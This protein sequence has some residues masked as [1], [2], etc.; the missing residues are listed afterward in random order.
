MTEQAAQSW[1]SSHRNSIPAVEIFHR[2]ALATLE[3][4]NKTVHDL[5]EIVALDPG[6]SISLFQQVN[7]KLQQRGKDAVESAHAAL[8]LLGDSAIADFIMQHQVLDAT[9]PDPAERQSYLQLISRTYH[10]QAQLEGFIDFQGISVVNEVLSAALL[11]NIGEFLACLFDYKQ[12]QQYQIKYRILGS[13]ANSAKPVFGFDFHELGRL[14]AKHM[15]LPPLV[16]ESLEENSSTGRKARLIQLAADISHQAEVGWYHSAMKATAEVCASF[17]N[18]SLD[19]FEKHLH[20]TAIESARA[21]PLHDVLPAAARLIMLPDVEPPVLN[22]DRGPG[23]KQRIN[24]LLNAAETTQVDFID[25]LM[26]FLH[27]DLNMSRVALLLLTPDKSKLGTR[28]AKGI[29]PASPI[30]TLV[31]DMNKSGLLKQLLSKPQGLWLKP[32]NYPNFEAALPA[33]FKSSFLHENFFLMSLFISGNPTGIVFCDRALA[34]NKLDPGSY[35]KFKSIIHHVSIALTQL[36]ERR[37][38][39]S[40]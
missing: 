6:M 38:R 17:L 24:K 5:A 7:A 26:T 32:D 31:I 4:H 36:A 8:I 30:N 27:E 14:Y 28:A 21:F 1:L 29:D 40:V 37:R 22:P 13:D 16:A 33:N 23:V 10:L 11:H 34:V 19:N 12:Y 20:Q 18:Q 3:D 35:Q 25:F 2:Q 9:H 39:Q 15:H